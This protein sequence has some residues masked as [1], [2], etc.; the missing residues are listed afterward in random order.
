MFVCLGKKGGEGG[1]LLGNHRSTRNEAEETKNNEREQPDEIR[2]FNHHFLLISF[3]V[4]CAHSPHRD[5]DYRPKTKNKTRI[6]TPR[7]K[8]TD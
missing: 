6:S 4:C 3:T 8:D 2:G 5:G 1:E 7:T